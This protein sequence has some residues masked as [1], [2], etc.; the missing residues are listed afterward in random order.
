[1]RLRNLRLQ[2]YCQHKSFNADFDSGITGIFGGNGSGKSN[3]LK[4][5]YI[6]LTNDFTRNPGTR[7]QSIRDNTPP[8]EPSFISAD[9]EHTTPFR[10]VVSLQPDR[11]ELWLPDQKKPMTS[12]K[13]I[14]KHIEK[15]IGLNRQL[16]DNYVFIDQRKLTEPLKA[17]PADRSAIFA[18]LCRTVICNKL[19]D[20]LGEEFS[21]EQ[22]LIVTIDQ[23]MLDN[24]RKQIGFEKKE[25]L[26]LAAAAAKLREA[27]L[28]E[29]QV[30]A[31]EAL[32]ESRQTYKTAK[33]TYADARSK[34]L[35]ARDELALAREKA[36]KA[37]AK[38]QAVG[39]A[40]AAKKQAAK[41]ARA[42]LTELAA[43][44]VTYSRRVTVKAALQTIKDALAAATPPD[45]PDNYKDY[46]GNKRELQRLSDELRDAERIVAALDEDGDKPVCGSCGSPI[47]NAA[48][49]KKTVEEHPPVIKKLQ[50]WVTATEAWQKRQQE[51][52]TRQAQRHDR[53]AALNQ[54]LATLADV[55]YDP[56]E[57][58][59]CQTV[60]DDYDSA[61]DS[62]A[63]LDKALAELTKKVSQLEA[64]E[65]LLL[66]VYRKAKAKYKALVKPDLTRLKRARIRLRRHNDAAAELQELAS[67]QKLA[68]TR[69]KAQEEVRDRLL[70]R[71]ELSA[72]AESWCQDLG[73]LRQIFHR[74]RLPKAVHESY[75]GKI[76]DSINKNLE[77]YGDPFRVV[78][79]D[80]LSFRYK[81]RRGVERD[82]A[83]LSGGELAVLALAFQ[84]AVAQIFAKDLNMCVLDEPTDGMDKTNLACFERALVGISLK[85]RAQGHQIIIVTHDVRLERV[86][87]RLIR[88]ENKNA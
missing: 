7:L 35:T 24:A 47:K 53:A 69:Q 81:K 55:D 83:W 62:V 20:D 64:K 14:Q 49:F 75:L 11:H 37:S 80:N 86:F 76:A 4:A 16:L 19:Y 77:E 38:Q 44:E 56:Q 50:G 36:A 2:N 57:A 9:W 82:I 65:G 60:I 45:P 66:P 27:Q 68:E 74:D 10:R 51:F 23:E 70:A 63:G 25:V 21:T 46:A 6:T 58:E 59:T 78:P 22:K 5:I 87:D 43:L 29:K 71:K 85:A 13:E 61:D 79:A 8:D 28:T 67:A 52:D 48:K 17:G 34:L 18:H 12:A 54:E 32:L 73:E 42:R 26:R 84:F 40:L 41:T 30:A 15:T 72:D 39:A 1:M 31:Q 88:I 33:E 3:L